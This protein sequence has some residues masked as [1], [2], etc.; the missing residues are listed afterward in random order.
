VLGNYVD[1]D[2]QVINQ[3]LERRGSM[4]TFVNETFG[5]PGPML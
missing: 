4:F 5:D 1:G 3:E 2:N